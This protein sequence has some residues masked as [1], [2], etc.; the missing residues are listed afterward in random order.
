MLQIRGTC[1]LVWRED[2]RL[3]TTGCGIGVAVR[4][5]VTHARPNSNH[6]ASLR[7]RLQFTISVPLLMTTLAAVLLGWNRHHQALRRAETLCATAMIERSKG[8]PDFKAAELK[9]HLTQ[10]ER[11]KHLAMIREQASFRPRRCSR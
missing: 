10:Y 6:E 8:E 2:N 4:I 3:K 5:G 11:Q 1:Q 7:R 9:A